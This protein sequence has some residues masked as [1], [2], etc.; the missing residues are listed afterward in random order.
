MKEL[1]KE[2]ERLIRENERL[3]VENKQIENHIEELE[4]ELSC[5]GIDISNQDIKMCPECKEW[6]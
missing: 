6:Q 5:C 3:R 1:I 2:T 4:E